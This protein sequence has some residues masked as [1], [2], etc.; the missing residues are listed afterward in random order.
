MTKKVVNLYT[1][2]PEHKRPYEEHGD[3]TVDVLLPRYGA[4]RVGRW[5]NGLLNPKPVRIQLDAIG[6]SV[7]RLCDGERSVREIGESLQAELGDRIEPVYERLE[8]FLTQMRNA[9]L[10]TLKHLDE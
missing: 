10:L 5:L 4:G 9:G 6:T 7:W 8:T 3:G 2:V 1:L